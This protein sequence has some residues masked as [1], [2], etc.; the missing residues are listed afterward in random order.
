[1][2]NELLAALA[3]LAAHQRAGYLALTPRERSARHRAVAAQLLA[4]LEQQQRGLAQR[5]QPV[6]N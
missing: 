4:M 6:S 1:M 2:A 3:T 5:R